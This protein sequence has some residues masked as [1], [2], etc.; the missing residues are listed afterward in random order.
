[1]NKA[2][3]FTEVYHEYSSTVLRSV[4]AQTGDVELGNEICQEVFLAYYE[5]MDRLDR[6][7]I[8]GWLLHTTK[9]KLIDHWRKN[10]S[11]R[12]LLMDHRSEEFPQ[13]VSDN[14][15]EKQ[16]CDRMVI[17]ELL[18]DIRKNKPRWYDVV[19]YVCVREMKPEEACKYLGI[20]PGMLRGRLQRARHYVKVKYGID[21]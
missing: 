13:E 4:V 2:E 8:K 20:S 14:N 17:C 18:E 3:T 7:Y 11:G 9:N 1:M 19:E 21:W 12:E 10:R 6:N 16:G 15:T 5:N